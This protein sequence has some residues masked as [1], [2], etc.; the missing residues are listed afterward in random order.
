[1]DRVSDS[2]IPLLN[3]LPIRPITEREFVLF[4]NLIHLE[5]G[6]F[7]GPTKKALLMGRLS[8]RLR[9]LGLRTFRAYYAL[10]ERD[11]A[12][13]TRMIDGICTHE[14]AFFREPHHFA[15]LEGRVFP[16]WMAEASQGRRARRVRAWSAGCSTGEEPY[17]LAMLLLHCF[18]GEHSWDLGILATGISSR[19]V[20][21]AER[22]VWPLEKSSE[23]PEAYLKRYMRRGIRSQGGKMKAGAKIRALVGSRRLNLSSSRYSVDGPCDLILCRNVVIYFDPPTRQRA[24]LRLIDLLAPTGLLL[25]GHAESLHGL[26][27]R[28]RNVIPT[29]YAPV[30]RESAAS[31]GG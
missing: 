21:Q 25:L 11:A 5:S 23:I 19:A 28:V 26:T 15:L 9:T 1:M 16:R 27:D 8:R 30:H 6:I 31:R 24:V 4:R 17:S 12:E 13:R 20:R 22:A 10:V 7:L 3:P 18:G 2:R 14:T 29:V